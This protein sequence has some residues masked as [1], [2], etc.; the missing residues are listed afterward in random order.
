MKLLLLTLLLTISLGSTSLFGQSF[1]KSIDKDS[2]LQVVL[3]KLPEG[4]KS[5]IQKIYND[6]N[7]EEKEFVLFMLSMPTSSREALI[8]NI[9]SNLDKINYLKSEFS[10]LVPKGY[11]VSIEFNPGEKITMTGESIDLRIEHIGAEP[12]DVKQEW[13]LKYNS[14][15]LNQML[16]PLKWT[17]E[18]IDHIKKLLAG[19]NCVSIENGEITTIGFARSGM[20]K[21]FF[22]LFNKDLTIADI[23]KYNDGCTYIFYKKNIVLEY[24]GGAVGPQCF[25]D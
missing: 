4:R 10:K 1:N 24:G 16:K 11:V 17:S 25:P 15:E 14:V 18:T 21:Y 3:K 2:L 6:G 8:A 12:R 7:D 19:A 23:K 5:E 9:D 13:N 22:K 20:G